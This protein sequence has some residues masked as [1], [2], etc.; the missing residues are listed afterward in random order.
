VVIPNDATNG[1]RALL[2][3]AKAGLI[4]LKDPTNILSTVKDITGTRKT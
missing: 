2:L 3:L 1:G 4:K